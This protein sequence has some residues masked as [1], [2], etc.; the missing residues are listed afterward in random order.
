MWLALL[1]ITSSCA[2][3]GPRPDNTKPMYGEVPKDYRYLATDLRFIEDAI[4]F[5][6]NRN[7]AAEY[8]LGVA[9]VYFAKGDLNVAM[10]RFNQAWLLN[11]EIPD[12]YFGFAKILEARKNKTD[13]ERFYK[14]AFEKDTNNTRIKNCF[15][16][17]VL[18]KEYVGNIV[19]MF[20]TINNF[21]ET[22]P[23]DSKAIAIAYLKMGYWQNELGK[24]SLALESYNK[25]IELNPN[26]ANAYMNRGYLFQTQNKYSKARIDYN[27]AIEIDST[28]IS[29]YCNRGGLELLL[30]NYEDAK[31]DFEICVRLESK[32]GELRR[33]LG[34]AKQKLND[35]E[36]AC[37]DFKLAKE[38]GD[39]EVEKLLKENCKT[40]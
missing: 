18:G 31:K 30:S 39:E 38:L 16:T 13:A 3:F 36:G 40:D 25:A 29:A 5:Y 4:K 11:P 23:D 27:K 14:I 20:E 21:I 32:S 9:W 22:F 24:D 12:A 17:I 2:I 10:M 8:Y 37:E 1:V 35:K 19:G 34:L 6:G 7:N 15:W 28:Y 33:H 26:S